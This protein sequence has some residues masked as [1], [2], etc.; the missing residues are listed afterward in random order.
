MKKLSILCF[1]LFTAVTA[2][3]DPAAV[4]AKIFP[5]DCSANALIETIDQANSAGGA[6][7]LNLAGRCAY[8][9]VQVNN[10]GESGDNGLPHNHLGH[11]RQRH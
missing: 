10:V 6:N 9:I 2:V 3:Q 8:N 1:V 11:Y 7:T 5:V 4:Q